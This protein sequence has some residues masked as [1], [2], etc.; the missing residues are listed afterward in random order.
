MSG[1]HHCSVPV[2]AVNHTK[3]ARPSCS[4]RSLHMWASLGSSTGSAFLSCSNRSLHKEIEEHPPAGP[5]GW[6]PARAAHHPGPAPSG[7]RSGRPDSWHPRP[8]RPDPTPA[9]GQGGNAASWNA[10]HQRKPAVAAPA[11]SQV[12]R[13]HSQRRPTCGGGSG[14]STGSTSRSASKLTDSCICCAACCRPWTSA[15]CFRS[16]SAGIAGAGGAVGWL[17]VAGRRVSVRPRPRVEEGGEA[18]T[19]GRPNQNA[20]CAAAGVP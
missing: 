1:C 15:S 9:A 6:P 18:P 17:Q 10:V 14:A 13:Q 8:H 19:T 12:G 5:L 3:P 2:Q 4:N 7:Q 16:S 20:R 11:S